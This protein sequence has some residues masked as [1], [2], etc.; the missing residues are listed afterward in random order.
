MRKFFS[1]VLLVLLSPFLF[2]ASAVL[3]CC[4]PFWKASY[5]KSPWFRDFG[6]KYVW[7]INGAAYYKIYNLTASMDFPLTYHRVKD[8]HFF[9]YG[10]RILFCPCDYVDDFYYDE[11]DG[12]FMVLECASS[13]E[14][15]EA[16]PLA[17]YLAK[18]QEVSDCRFRGGSGR[19]RQGGQR[20]FCG[21]CR[22]KRTKAAPFLP[23]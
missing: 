19:S 20:A 9:A 10:Q 3:L 6:E 16:I 18:V 13:E 12:L 14:E 7:G 5:K 23:L 15:R 1:G 11:K 2:V 21:L 17:E 8:Y 22:Q 4:L